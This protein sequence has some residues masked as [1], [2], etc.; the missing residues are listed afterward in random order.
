MYLPDT[1]SRGLLSFATPLF[2][3]IEKTF[4]PVFAEEDGD[5]VFEVEMPGFSKEDVKVRL[6]QHGHLNLEGLMKR[7]AIGK[8]YADW[9]GEVSDV[10]GKKIHELFLAKSGGIVAKEACI[11]WTDQNARRSTVGWSATGILMNDSTMSSMIQYA[12]IK[13]F[14]NSIL[15]S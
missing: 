7:D 3:E 4:D 8:P 14:G 6:D 11:G 15:R 13:E 5:Y 9:F 2:T 1:F 10:V 12:G